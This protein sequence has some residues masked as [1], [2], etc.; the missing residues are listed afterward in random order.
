MEELRRLYEADEA[1]PNAVVAWEAIGLILGRNGRLLQKGE[2]PYRLPDWINKYLLRT[3]DKIGRLWLG[4]RPED[5][6]PLPSMVNE[7]GELRKIPQG[8][9][10]RDDRI[11]H[12]AS[13][14][15]FV[16]QGASAF[17]RHDRIMRDADYLRIYDNPDLQDNKPYQKEIRQALVHAM[18]KNEGIAT[19]EAV[20]N[21]LS[22]ARAARRSRPKGT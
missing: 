9:R 1:F 10:Y 19:E 13:A 6:R 12:L 11:G 16:R 14:L 20:R 4:I 8:N 22:K 7:I 5:D 17:H 18:M 3:A 21:R 2:A 15:G